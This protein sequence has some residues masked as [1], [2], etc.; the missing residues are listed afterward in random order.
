MKRPYVEDGLKTETRFTAKPT[1]QEFITRIIHLTF[2]LQGTC[3]LK[4]ITVFVLED[5]PDD[6]FFLEEIM[7]QA[8]DFTATILAAENFSQTYSIVDNHDIDVAILD[9]SLPDSEGLSTF[10]SFHQRYPTI[11]TIILSG[12]KDEKLAY[13]AITKGAQ[14]YLFKGDPSPTAIIR[15][16]RYAIERQRLTTELREAMAHIKQLQGLL[17][18]CC[19]CKNIRDD[20]GYWKSVEHYFSKFTSAQFSHGI[21]PDCARKHYPDIFLEK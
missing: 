14:D 20:A 9:L 21:C 5:N 15:T 4:N 18:I 6:L 7:A 8:K 10:T 11:P 3:M 19:H 17:P 12:E 16:I 13:E 1:Q 2:S